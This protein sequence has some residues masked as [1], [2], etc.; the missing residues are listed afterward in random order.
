M[1]IY[2]PV[3][4]DALLLR[5]K[6]EEMVAVLHTNLLGP[7]LTCRAA[8]RSMLRTPGAAIVNIGLLQSFYISC[9]LVV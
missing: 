3:I 5:T 9:R 7:M 4:R 1:N 8:L 6:P 2:D